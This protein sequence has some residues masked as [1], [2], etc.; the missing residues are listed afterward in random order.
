MG[1]F[2]DFGDDFIEGFAG[3]DY[4]KDYAHA[5]KLMKADSFA[6]APN[7]KFLFHVYFNLNI[8]S[9]SADK[10][11]VGALVKS[12]TLPSFDLDT[13][14]YVQYNRKRNVHNRIK[15]KPVN[16]TFHDDS[17]DTVRSMWHNYYRYYFSDTDY[18]YDT[19]GSANSLAYTPRNIYDPKFT[20]P[21][22]GITTKHSN[23]PKKPAFFKDIKI[24]GFSR[25]NY[26]LYT[27]INPTI[28]TFSHDT[29]DYEQSG[30]T[31]THEMEVVYEAVK[32]ARGTMDKASGVIGFGQESEDRYDTSPSSL[33][34]PGSTAS[35]LGAGGVL[36]AVT[37][38]STDLSKGNVLGALKKIGT[39]YKTYDDQTDS[40]KDA[41]EE[42]FLREA[43]KNLP[44]VVTGISKKIGGP[45]YPKASQNKTESP[46]GSP[47]KP[48]PISNTGYD[49]GKRVY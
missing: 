25:G 8:P 29:Y 5:S 35:I 36:D 15:Y 39:T 24:F 10:G 40:V 31:M 22:W 32:Y 12:I 34:K 33:T 1:I 14:E 30:G 3:A 47:K 20:Y 46:T 19:S 42:E 17:S 7:L 49:F 38:A 43:A 45:L 6:N 4:V 26:I 23:G 2:D 16:V 44:S 13:Q 11:L 48:E 21:T 18:D 9:I 41:I 28:S 27:L 37:G